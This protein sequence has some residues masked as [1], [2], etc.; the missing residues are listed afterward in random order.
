MVVWEEGVDTSQL[1]LT[2]SLRLLKMP[3]DEDKKQMYVYFKDHQ[4]WSDTSPS[5]L[6]REQGDNVGFWKVL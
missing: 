5:P 2:M 1:V 4:G 6:R 3:K